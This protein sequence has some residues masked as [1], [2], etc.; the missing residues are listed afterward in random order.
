MLPKLYLIC[1]LA[2]SLMAC[3]KLPPLDFCLSDPEAGGMQCVDKKKKNYFKRYQDS[4]ND[5][6]MPNPD[7][8]I[9]VDF[10]AEH[11]K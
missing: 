1:F 7:F 5:V 8:K 2:F 4:G 3:E 6:C 11:C 10:L 9:L